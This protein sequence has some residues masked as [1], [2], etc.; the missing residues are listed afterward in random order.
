MHKVNIWFDLKYKKYQ[1]THKRIRRDLHF[2]FWHN[3]TKE[4]EEEEEVE[5]YKKFLVLFYLFILIL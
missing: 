4:N 1:H 5:K 3:L 2:I